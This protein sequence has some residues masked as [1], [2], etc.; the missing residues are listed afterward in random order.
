M[1]TRYQTQISAEP[2]LGVVSCISPE[3]QNE[4]HCWKTA[5]AKSHGWSRALDTSLILE[6]TL[7][8]VPGTWLMT[9]LRKDRS[10]GP[11]CANEA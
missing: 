7:R 6:L 4:G 3:T 5:S 2:V 11:N 1:P 10:L 9:H 8:T